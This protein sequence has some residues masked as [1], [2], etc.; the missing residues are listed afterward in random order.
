MSP[1]GWL[2]E[3]PWPLRLQGAA[4]SVCLCEVFPWLCLSVRGVAPGLLAVPSARGALRERMGLGTPFGRRKEEEGYFFQ[5][6]LSLPSSV[7]LAEPSKSSSSECA[8]RVLLCRGCPLLPPRVIPLME[9]FSR[10]FPRS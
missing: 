4:L 5:L 6:S 7:G 10:L 8:W 1:E 3:R 9:Y 2:G